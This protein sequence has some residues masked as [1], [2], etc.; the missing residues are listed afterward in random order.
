MHIRKGL[1]VSA[2]SILLA[3][4]GGGG[5]GGSS[6]P[7]PPAESTGVFQAGKIQG[8]S[9]RTPTRS[10]TTNAAGAF[11]Y[12]PGETVTFSIGGIELG[13]T[14]GAPQIS[15]FTLAGATPPASELALRRE[16]S[17]MQ[18][19]P[20]PTPFVR[21]V[22][23]SLL[24]LA[25]DADD[26]SSNGLDVS[27]GNTSLAGATLTV[28][29]TAGGFA[30]RLYRLAPGLNQNIPRTRSIGFLFSSLGLRVSGGAVVRLG[31]ST[32][33]TSSFSAD[34]AST[35]D[36]NGELTATTTT[37]APSLSTGPAHVT[38]T[39]DSMG[40]ILHQ[41]TD[42]DTDGNGVA[43]VTHV[44]DNTYDAHGNQIA[45][46]ET[47]FFSATLSTT[48]SMIS[49]FD[50]FGRMLTFDF[51][52]GVPVGQNSTEH[53]EFH[54]DA[55]GN[56]LDQR[57]A[58]DFTDDGAPEVVY[59]T[60][61]TYDGSGR[62]AT[63]RSTR[64]DGGDGVLDDIDSTTYTYNAAG[65]TDSLVT[66]SDLDGDGNV[67]E[68]TTSHF[69][70]DA[71]GLLSVQIDDHEAPVGTISERTETRYTYDAEART[72]STV[73]NF[74]TGADGS[75]DEVRTETSTYDANGF[76]TASL[77]TTDLEND[78]VVDTRTSETRT[79]DA[80]GANLTLLSQTDLDADGTFDQSTGNSWEYAPVDNGV[81]QLIGQY[82]QV[83]GASLP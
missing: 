29:V 10:G 13:S 67:D 51:T 49:T 54:W 78:G 1:V 23:L 39:H 36:A 74:D 21:A 2:F 20:A 37:Y 27:A 65:S 35:Y 25:L 42:F 9:W 47:D 41:R 70:P 73:R 17:H 80:N 77:G 24:V 15:L 57:T 18:T 75:V 33:G 58:V 53:G 83:G 61:A 38:I 69:T 62:L 82:F 56:L 30:A 52:F 50:P 12:L 79:Y 60:S 64:D 11:K 71:R 26:D 81:V 40:R 5:G 76:L 59:A 68:R 19:S 32:N 72:L 31:S 4:C 48:S 43:D 8:V 66:T 7:P 14:A 16:I 63:S 44:T 22:N 46:V 3:A 55:Q 6:T 45:N 28:G 34:V